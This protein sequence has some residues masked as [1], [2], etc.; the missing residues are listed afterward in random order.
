MELTDAINLRRTVRDFFADRVP[1]DVVKKALQAGL[2]APSY[3]HQ[4]QWDFILVKDKDIRLQLTKTEEMKDKIDED[5]KKRFEMYDPLS[6]EMYLDAI[7]KQRRMIMEAPEL[8]IVVYKPK[9]QIK[10]SQRVYDLNCLASVWCCIENILLSLAEDNVF[11]VTFIPQNTA[12]V[13]DVLNIPQ[14]ME[15]AAFIPFGYKAKDAKILPQKEVKLEEKL[16]I[17]RW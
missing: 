13:K 1:Y 5:L 14:E 4:K 16:H 17:D 6:K 11:G 9:T 8:L 7:P 10:E 3:N 15:V 12:L 2:K